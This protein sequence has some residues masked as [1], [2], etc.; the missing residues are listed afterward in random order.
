MSQEKKEKEDVRMD[1]LKKG[2]FVITNS[3]GDFAEI[4]TIFKTPKEANSDVFELCD[5]GNDTWITSRHPVKIGE[6]WFRP[7]CHFPVEEQ[8]LEAVYKLV[9]DKHHTIFS[10]KSGLLFTTLGSEALVFEDREMTRLTDQM[11]SKIVEDLKKT[12]AY[13]TGLFVGCRILSAD[14]LT[15]L[16]LSELPL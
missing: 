13:E 16:G 8:D 7:K 10:P 4:L 1:E 2:D 12:N 9:L 5:V 11:G 15:Y 3:N 6:N 14:K